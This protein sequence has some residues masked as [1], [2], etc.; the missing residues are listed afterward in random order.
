MHRTIASRITASCLAVSASLIVLACTPKNDPKSSPPASSQAAS[1][2]PGPAHPPASPRVHGRV[3]MKTGQPFLSLNPLTANGRVDLNILKYHLH[4]Y[5]LTENPEEVE[6]VPWLAKSLPDVEDGGLLQTWTLRKARWSDGRPVSTKDVLFTW[7]LLTHASRPETVAASAGAAAVADVATIEALDEHRFR[8]RY[9]RPHFRHWLDF[10]AAFPI[11]AAHAT[12]ADPN[13]AAAERFAKVNLGP[14]GITSWTREELQLERRVPWWGDAD[15]RFDGLF[16][17]ERFNYR[18]VTDSVL[19]RE[20]LKK[21]ELDIAVIYKREDFEALDRAKAA[22][23]LETAHYNLSQW[24]FIGWNARRPPFDDVR[25]RKA[26]SHL[27]PRKQINER[28]FDGDGGIVAGPFFGCEGVLQDPEIRAPRLSPT[29]ALKLLEAAG[30]KDSD[31]DGLLDQEGKA[32]RFRLLYPTEGK[33][34]LEGPLKVIQNSFAQAGIHMELDGRLYGSLVH[35]K[36]GLLPRG[37]FDAFT[38]IWTVDPLFPDLQSLYGTGGAWNWC[39]YGNP[40]LDELFDEYAHASDD[41]AR[42][43]TARQIQEILAA[44]QPHLWLFSN[45]IWVVWN[46]RLKGVHTH[47]L[48]IRQWEFF[49]DGED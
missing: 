39:G 37:D 11:V 7:K 29:K 30:W 14:Y 23:G 25:V 26:L 19:T 20:L 17:V 16:S 1:P 45:P 36:E 6:A 4:C 2:Q 8:V 18:L 13:E 46:T 42:I 24:S 33:A 47:H 44:D 32:F 5:L 21:G 10:G 27:V 48:G 15:R 34:S 40:T 12:P 35:P 43:M 28:F 31:G 3:V 22:L 9:K 41:A 49:V 38:L